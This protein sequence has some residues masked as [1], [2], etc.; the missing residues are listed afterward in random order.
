MALFGDFRINLLMHRLL[1]VHGSWLEAHVP[2]PRGPG[3]AP[4]LGRAGPPGG[5][6]PG[7]W[8]G[9]APLAMSHEPGGGIK[10]RRQA[11]KQASK[12]ERWMECCGV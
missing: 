10:R 2:W 8:A 7:P 6:P 11:G 5:A 12:P 4:R 1:M 9:R 3:P